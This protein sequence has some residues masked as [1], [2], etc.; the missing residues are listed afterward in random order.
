MH[1]EGKV[2]NPAEETAIDSKK[3]LN[4]CCM[5]SETD[6]ILKK[7]LLNSWSNT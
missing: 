5:A 3:T 7:K 1:L 6:T 4:K 2:G